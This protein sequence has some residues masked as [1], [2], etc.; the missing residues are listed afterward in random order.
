MIALAFIVGMLLGMAIFSVWVYDG[1]HHKWSKWER[2]QTVT[3]SVFKTLNG[4]I[5]IGQCRKC[6]LCGI[7]ELKE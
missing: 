1:C 5:G 7:E 4:Q 6:E 3:S 2:C